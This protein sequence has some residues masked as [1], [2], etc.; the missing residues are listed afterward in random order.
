LRRTPQLHQQKLPI[1][2]T[3][4]KFPLMK[5][6]FLAPVIA[7]LLGANAVADTVT[8]Q[9]G[10]KIEGRIVNETPESVTIQFSV[11]E[12]IRDERTIPR[13]EIASVEKLMPDELLFQQLKNVKPNPTTSLPVDLYESMGSL[14]EDFL[15]KYPASA[16]AA[17]IEANLAALKAERQRVQRG[18]VKYLGAW[19]SPDEAARRKPQIEAQQLFATMKDLAARGD[20]VGAL[21]TFSRI[22][23][24]YPG[25]RTFPEA[26][27]LARQIVP[28][29]KQDVER[30]QRAAKAQEAEFQQRVALIP[31]PGRTQTLAA[32][33][34]E[35]EQAEAALSRAEKSGVTWKPLLPRSP[36]SLD[37]LARQAAAEATR[38]AALPVPAMRASIEITDRA[39][40]SISGKDYATA[41]ALLKE[42]TAKWSSNEE[43]QYW[44]KELKELRAAPSPSPEAATSPAP[45]APTITAKPT[46]SP[47]IRVKATPAPRTTPSPAVTS[48]EPAAKARP[49]FMTIPGALAIVGAAIVIIVITTFASRRKTSSREGQ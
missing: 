14:L 34:R 36:R 30:R 28:A 45:P 27:E 47:A 18:E 2:Q 25:T 21:N 31:E 12:S 1:P 8:L 9:S 32:R 16:H 17:E 11:S 44:T 5:T 20:Y 40:R 42:A 7:V 23:K 13:S 46:G 26:V 41:E 43:A 15:R 48:P 4:H 19:L 10:E 29:L 3:L 33:K 22:E 37:N 6:W 35:Q 38:L 24:G 39:K 49:F